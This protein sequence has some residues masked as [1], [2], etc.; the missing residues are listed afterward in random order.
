M[1]SILIY[2]T[3][4]L[5]DTLVSLPAIQA[6]REGFPRHALI[7]LTDRHARAELVSSWEILKAT[8]LIQ[9]VIFYTPAST[10]FPPASRIVNAACAAPWCPATAM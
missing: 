5:G 10:A 6:I 3:G 8:G 4:Q 7:L 9:R 2:R 1:P